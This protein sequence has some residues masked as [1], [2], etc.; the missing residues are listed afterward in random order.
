MNGINLT[1]K[2]KAETIRNQKV[3]YD[4]SCFC[5]EAWWYNQQNYDVFYGNGQFTD[6]TIS[7]CQDGGFT[8]F[9]AENH[10]WL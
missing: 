3:R 10:D 5:L 7:V 1:N 8:F 9:D 6:D 4:K 2:T